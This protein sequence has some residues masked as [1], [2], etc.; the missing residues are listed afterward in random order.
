MKRWIL[1]VVVILLLAVPAS[2][3][4][5]EPYF[6]T[7]VETG[8]T[9]NNDV[10]VFDG[11]LEVEES[12]V[13][14][15]DVVVFNGDAAIDGTVNGDLVIFNGDLDAGSQ[16]RIQGD[17]VLLN[18]DV[19]NQSPR[20]IR[21]TNIEGAVLPGIVRGIPPVPAVPAVPDKPA[22]P[23]APDAP[24]APPVPAV[25]DTGRTSRV[26]NAFAD[27]T[28][29]LFS[30]LL[31]GGLAF[32]VAAAFPSNLQRVNWTMRKKPAASG[33]VGFL[34][35]LA[36]PIVMAI[37]AV[38]SAV[39]TIVCIGLLGFP[40]IMVIALALVAAVVMG[41]IGAGFWL[42]ER[43][44]VRKGTSLPLQAALGTFILTFAVG[45][46]GMLTGGWLEGLLGIVITSVGLG[47]VALTQFGRKSYMG[48][49]EAGPTEED[50]DKI[51]VVLST[52][53]DDNA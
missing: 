37:L 39:L 26:G 2:T 32:V 23:D 20:N 25:R 40:I 17:C 15:G 46:L 48:P 51:S 34:T 21:C 30:S 9:I 49:P 43:L 13:V 8:E 4:L 19:D 27:F 3:V 42:G 45:L 50:S 52:L 6:D 35:A 22:V 29:T 14:N 24:D 1:I 36:V 7:V 33:A 28:R 47:A 53:P 16:A 44:I 41:W 10:I 18:G 12:A 5:A 11:D 31:L 38:I